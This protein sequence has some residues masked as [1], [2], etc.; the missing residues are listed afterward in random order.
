[1]DRGGF[2]GSVT[3]TLP[4]PVSFLAIGSWSDLLH[5]GTC[6]FDHKVC[7]YSPHFV[8]ITPLGTS[9]QAR[10]FSSPL[11]KTV[12]SAAAAC[13]VAVPRASQQ[14]ASRSVQVAFHMPCDQ[15]VN[16]LSNKVFPSSTGGSQS[17]QH[18]VPRVPKIPQ[19][20]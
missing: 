15:C 17:R 5:P 16:I 14:E 1:M 20:L 11:G 9:C 2:R 3:V 18:T 12:N 8:T 6:F 10:P 13:I 19:Q 4:R 7:G